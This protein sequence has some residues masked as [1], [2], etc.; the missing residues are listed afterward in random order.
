MMFFDNEDSGD[1]D[2][3]LSLKSYD[4]EVGQEDE[5][6]S[7]GNEKENKQEPN[8]SHLRL[9]VLVNGEEM[10]ESEASVSESESIVLL[11]RKS[12]NTLHSFPRNIQI[13]PKERIQLQRVHPKETSLRISTK[14]VSPATSTSLSTKV[15][16]SL[17]KKYPSKEKIPS[18]L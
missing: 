2:L 13:M 6:V 10:S 12:D 17:P 7:L 5:E 11:Q 9:C 4:E 14:R 8:T 18:L 15:K 3:S 1:D 16:T